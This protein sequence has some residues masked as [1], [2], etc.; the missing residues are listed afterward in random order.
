[1]RN[2]AEGFCS[3]EHI[4]PYYLKFGTN[5]LTPLTFMPYLSAIPI[6]YLDNILQLISSFSGANG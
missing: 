2:T 5:L 4:Y 3:K 6:Q 1:M